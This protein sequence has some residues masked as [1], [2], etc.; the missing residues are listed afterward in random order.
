MSEKRDSRCLWE[1]RSHREN[2]AIKSGSTTSH[3]ALPGKQNTNCAFLM[4]KTARYVS[5]NQKNKTWQLIFLSEELQGYL[6]KKKLSLLD[7][8]L[9]A[10]ITSLQI[11]GGNE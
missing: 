6:K 3:S 5:H 11:P 4:Y 9:K 8:A 2:W 10:A 7:C 1:M